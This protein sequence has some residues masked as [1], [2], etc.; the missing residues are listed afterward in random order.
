MAV[1]AETPPAAQSTLTSPVNIP[2][3]ITDSK[4]QDGSPP[5]PDDQSQSKT[6]KILVFV[7]VF[8]SMFLVAL[9][10]TIISTAI[11]QI[12]DEFHSLTEVG[13]YGSAYLLTCC[14]FQLLFGKLYTLYPVKTVLLG[15]IL[16][17][18]ISSAVC[19]AAPNSIAFI[20]GRAVSGVGAAG[21]FAGTIVSIVHMVP[22]HKRPQIQGLFGA[23][24]GLA[25]ITGPLVGGAFTSNVT[26]RWCFYINLPLGGVAMLVIVVYFHVPRNDNE[27]SKLPWAKKILHLDLLGTSCLV[28]GVVC[29]VLALQWGGQQYAW[30]NGR[31]I[32][33]LT[34]M[35]VLLLGFVAVQIFVPETATLPTRI[36]KQRSVIAGFWQTLCIGSGNYIFIYFLPLW[37]Q[38]I[39]GVSAV[40]SGIRLLPVMLSIVAGSI[41]GGATTPKIGYYTPWAIFGSSLM[42]V[43]A[44]LLTTLEVD[45]TPASKWIGYQ[46]IYGLGMG[47]C[48]Q[49]PNLAA[50]TVLPKKDVPI[51]LALMFFGQLIGAAVF[52][53]VGENVL[54]NQLVQRLSSIPGFDKTLVT[55]GGATAILGSVPIEFRRSVLIA[56]NEALRKVFQVGLIVSCFTVLGAV[57]LEWRSILERKNESDVGDE[58]G[59]SADDEVEKTEG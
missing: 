39:K 55:D 52:V 4:S 42:S 12:T 2:P 27:T 17:F 16:L 56:Y 22:L 20:V 46:V 19:G 41:I 1:K 13:W 25:S 29:L 44:G 31:I 28:P 18:E 37:F 58:K 34:V 26:W 8:L 54:G 6:K 5:K 36:F 50:Q 3:S 30:S 57:A 48:F 23:L 53:A 15:S 35:S 10:R 49:V 51:G 11:P 33:L 43:G 24:F 14:A 21:I 40:D 47:L 7:S 9:D 38:S 32:A 59:H 45:N